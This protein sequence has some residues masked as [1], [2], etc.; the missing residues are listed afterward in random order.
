M[1]SEIPVARYFPRASRCGVRSNWR[2]VVAR[3]RGPMSGRHPIVRLI[4]TLN[5]IKIK[6]AEISSTF[7]NIIN[8]L[9]GFEYRAQTALDFSIGITLADAALPVQP[10]TR[11]RCPCRTGIQAPY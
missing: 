9:L 8:A 3:I 10:R 7:L 6:T 4:P 1:Q 11:V 2:E 5:R